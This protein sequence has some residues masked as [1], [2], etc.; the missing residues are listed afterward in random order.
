MVEVVFNL[1][2]LN[3]RI[4]FPIQ[5]GTFI[6]TIPAGFEYDKSLIE[7]LS[8]TYMFQDIITNYRVVGVRRDVI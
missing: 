3:S 7:I 5:E 2:A 6:T 4:V 8:A 1:N